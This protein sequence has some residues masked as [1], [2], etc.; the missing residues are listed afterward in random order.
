MQGLTAPDA[1][2]TAQGQGLCGWARGHKA[3]PPALPQAGPVGAEPRQ[4]WALS[5]EPALAMG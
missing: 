2:V 5:D 3:R 1:R 4:R